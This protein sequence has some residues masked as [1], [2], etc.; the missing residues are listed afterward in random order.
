M[1]TYIDYHVHTKFSPDS[2]ADIVAYI[3]RAKKLGL[4]HVLFTD[5]IDFGTL[6][7]YFRDIDFDEYFKIMKELE[8]RYDFPIKIGVEIGYEKNCK[9]EIEEFLH[10]YN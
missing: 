1:M 3:N 9:N 5:H 2:N 8:S 7:P 4:K 6:D 10:Q